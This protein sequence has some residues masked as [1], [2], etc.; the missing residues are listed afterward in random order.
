MEY[1]ISFTLFLDS[2]VQESKQDITNLII[3]HLDSAGVT[4]ENIKVTYMGE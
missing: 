1:E 2:D 3:D 4:L